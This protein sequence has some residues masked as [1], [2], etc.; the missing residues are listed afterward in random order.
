VRAMRRMT[1]VKRVTKQQLLATIRGD[2]QRFERIVERVPGELLSE[3][4]LAGGWSVKDVLAHV[5]WGER[6]AI[7]VAKARALVHQELWDLPEYELNELVVRES[8]THGLGEVMAEYRAAFDEFVA[9]IEGMSDDDLNEPDR[10]RGLTERIPGWRPW[11][12]LYDPDHYEDHG[13]AIAAA[14]AK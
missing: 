13:R 2:R 12:V 14:L 4:I 10:I 6:E 3:P 1:V 9:A 5:A 8:R 7:A 11:R